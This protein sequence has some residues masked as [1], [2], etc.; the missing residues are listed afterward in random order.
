MGFIPQYGRPAMIPDTWASAEEVVQIRGSYAGKPS[1]KF[2]NTGWWQPSQDVRLAG[3]VAFAYAQKKRSPG[4]QYLNISAP[5][6][7][8]TGSGGYGDDCA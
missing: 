2:S 3:A 4:P 7:T 1:P 6:T 5:A 8:G